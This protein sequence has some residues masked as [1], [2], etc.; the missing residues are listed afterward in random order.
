MRLIF[1]T[2]C[3]L[4]VSVEC[5]ESEKNQ[6]VQV[7]GEES[8]AAI[9]GTEPVRRFIYRG[10]PYQDGVTYEDIHRALFGEDGVITKL[11]KRFL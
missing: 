7:F 2:D 4:N 10:I 5:P 3:K 11:P 8:D 1:S 9:E 6:L